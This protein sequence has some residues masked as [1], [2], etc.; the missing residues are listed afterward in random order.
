MRAVQHLDTVIVEPEHFV[1]VD[2]HAPVADKKTVLFQQL[3]LHLCKIVRGPA[4]AVIGD[5]LYHMI[6]RQSVMDPGKR[7]L[8]GLP[9]DLYVQFRLLTAE[10]TPQFS[11]KMADLFFLIGFEQIVERM[12]RKGVPDIFR[13][14]SYKHDREMRVFLPQLL[15][16]LDPVCALHADIQKNSL[17]R[18]GGKAAEKF[19]SVCKTAAEK[20][21]AVKILLQQPLQTLGICILIFYD[22]HMKFHSHAPSQS[23]CTIS[24]T[25]LHGGLRRKHHVSR[26]I[27]KKKHRAPAARM[28]LQPFSEIDGA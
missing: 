26:R 4:F 3:L 17:C 28:P 16:G 7:Q 21:L 6:P 24:E 12:D 1:H 22:R 18:P 14:R 8:H 2:D 5:D 20:G 25:D 13:R 10:D 27:T 23:Y 9:C 15:C 19:V 11:D